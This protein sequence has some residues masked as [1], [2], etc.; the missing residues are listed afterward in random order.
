MPKSAKNSE[1]F[2]VRKHLW[3]DTLR[4]GDSTPQDFGRFSILAVFAAEIKIV[5][6]VLAAILKLILA[7]L[8]GYILEKSLLKSKKKILK[9]N[10]KN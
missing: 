1:N 10:L 4:G 2:D 7:V 3:T 9:S 5:L 6:A 8:A